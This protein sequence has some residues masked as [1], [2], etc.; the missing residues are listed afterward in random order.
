M[1]SYLPNTCVFNFHEECKIRF[2]KIFKDSL[3]N[4]KFLPIVVSSSIWTHVLFHKIFI[5]EIFFSSV[6]QEIWKCV[7]KIFSSV[8]SNIFFSNLISNVG[9]ILPIF[10]CWPVLSPIL[11]YN[12]NVFCNKIGIKISR[13]NRWRI[14]R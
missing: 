13:V 8:H 6:L 2:S 7:S 4:T 10:K 5:K 11:K 9:I 1:K 3:W 14:F 12:W